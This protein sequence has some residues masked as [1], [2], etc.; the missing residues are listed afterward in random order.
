MTYTG[1]RAVL[2]IAAR[3]VRALALVPYLQGCN[4]CRF[5]RS[6]NLFGTWTFTKR[7]DGRFARRSRPKGE[8]QGCAE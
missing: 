3:R 5:C 2:V 8:A 6:K 7:Q 1:L 4:V